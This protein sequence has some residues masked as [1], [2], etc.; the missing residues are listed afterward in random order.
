[1]TMACNSYHLLET[2]SECKGLDQDVH[3]SETIVDGYK[4]LPL[5][6]CSHQMAPGG[7]SQEMTN[8]CT[9]P[10]EIVDQ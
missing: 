4:F 2:A 8:F 5:G 3:L 9:G 10:V 7:Y 1:M 6:V